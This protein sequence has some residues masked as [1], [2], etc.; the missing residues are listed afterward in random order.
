MYH[1][2]LQIKLLCRESITGLP[3]YTYTVYTYTVYIQFI[4]FSMF[5]DQQI[6]LYEIKLTPPPPTHP[7]ISTQPLRKVRF[8]PIHHGPHVLYGRSHL[9]NGCIRVTKLMFSQ[10]CF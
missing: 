10:N 1:F 5:I 4:S 8:V 9:H 6:I 3:V 7:P 2:I